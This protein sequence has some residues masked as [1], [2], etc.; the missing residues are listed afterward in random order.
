MANA[1]VLQADS[2]TEGMSDN[3]AYHPILKTLK[4]IIDLRCALVLRALGTRPVGAVA[5]S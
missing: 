5:A 4:T 2:F 3:S 1:I